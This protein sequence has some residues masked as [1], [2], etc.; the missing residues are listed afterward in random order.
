MATPKIILAFLFLNIY[1]NVCSQ[2]STEFSQIDSLKTEKDAFALIRKYFPKYNSNETFENYRNETRQT[3]DSFKV[4]N[5]VKCDIDNNGETDLLIFRAD[6][7]PT[8]FA[9]LSFHNNF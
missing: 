7:L 3:A 8:I 2:I 6:K 5:W 9:V 4:R 1:V